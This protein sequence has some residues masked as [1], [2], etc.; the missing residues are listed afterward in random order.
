MVS[1]TST[2]APVW[3]TV[4]DAAA[5]ARCGAKLIYRAADSGALKSARAGGRLYRFKNE[6]VDAW[7][8]SSVTPRENG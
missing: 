2:T 5:R 7:I 3:L 4:K 6:W 8:E 1:D